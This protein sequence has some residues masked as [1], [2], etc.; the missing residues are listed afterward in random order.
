[1]AFATEQDPPPYVPPPPEGPQRSIVAL[2]LRDPF[3]W[4]ALGWR[5]M[6][7]HA[8]IAL[9]Y[10]FCFWLMAVVLALVFRSKPEYV[11]SIA[12]GCLLV[13][14][15]L[16]M[17]LY[18]VSRRRE[19]GIQ[20]DLA[21]SLTCWDTRLRSIGLLVMV[22]VVLELIWGRASLV[23]FAV[24][25]NTAM[26]STTGVIQAIFNPQNWEFVAVYLA[27]G[28]AFAVLVYAIAVVSIPMILDRDT[29]AISACIT[30][31]QVVFKNTGVMILWGLLIALLV[32]L[33]LLPWGLGLV[34]VGP[35]LGHATWHAYR[36]S[37]SWQGD[38]PLAVV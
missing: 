33:A 32:A 38:A 1:M 28:G 5:D 36:G 22:L 18:D 16:A 19:S 13:G 4:L 30:S 9:F 20:P 27:V 35:W 7:A 8:G 26:P 12:S 11:M 14:P 23:V 34:L 17:G 29:D 21:A 24:F 25:F 6:R 15:F 3:H 2:R 31:I 10:G 37:V